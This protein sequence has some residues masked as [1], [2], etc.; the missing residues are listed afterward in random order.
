MQMMAVPISAIHPGFQIRILSRL[1]QSSCCDC[2][3]QVSHLLCTFTVAVQ[4]SGGFLVKRALL[5]G[6]ALLTCAS[7]ALPSTVFVT[8]TPAF[9]NAVKPPG[10]PKFKSAD[11]TPTVNG[12]TP[13]LLTHNPNLNLPTAKV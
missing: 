1:L 9:N 6:I 12:L 2:V 7:T 11:G 3:T 5:A 13:A 4:S 8:G 10:Q